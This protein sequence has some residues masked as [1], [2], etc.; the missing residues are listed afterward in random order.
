MKFTVKENFKFGT[1]TYEAGNTHDS[2]NIDGMSED[3]VKLFHRSG[4]VDVEG[5]ESVERV[6]TNVK[7]KPDNTQV[8]QALEEG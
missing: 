2:D 4:W 5:K 7:L 3:S 6:V 1:A 8:T